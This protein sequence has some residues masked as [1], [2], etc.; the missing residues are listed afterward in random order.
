MVDIPVILANVKSGTITLE[1]G[2]ALIGE[3]IEA[4]A[5]AAQDRGAA[6]ACAMQGLLA[7][8]WD[9]DITG[10]TVRA[11]EHADALIAHLDATR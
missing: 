1:E 7:A 11:V 9:K 5:K 6:A 8:R 2:E 10:T 3:H 4:A